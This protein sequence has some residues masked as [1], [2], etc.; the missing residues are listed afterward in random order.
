MSGHLELLLSYG[1]CESCF[2]SA[3]IEMLC[4]LFSG[5]L[6]KSVRDNMLDLLADIVD[7]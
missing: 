4:G 6:C 5:Q 2:G 7:D 1:T 3:C